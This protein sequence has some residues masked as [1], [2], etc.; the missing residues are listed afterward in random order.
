MI[1]YYLVIGV[2]RPPHLCSDDGDNYLPYQAHVS[3]EKE[4]TFKELNKVFEQDVKELWSV[5][6]EELKEGGPEEEVQDWLLDKGYTNA[7]YVL[8]SS[9]PFPEDVDIYGVDLANDYLG[10]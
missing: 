8:V 10:C 3:S 4:L 7:D 1:N 5:M 2:H 9:E 6:Y